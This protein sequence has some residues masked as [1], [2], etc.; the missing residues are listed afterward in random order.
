M[1]R[2]TSGFRVTYDN[3]F[4]V[5]C[6]AAIAHSKKWISNSG[7]HIACLWRP[8]TERDH[9]PPTSHPWN[10]SSGVLKKM[11]CYTRYRCHPQPFTDLKR[12]ILSR[13][14]R[15][16]HRTQDDCNHRLD[17]CSVTKGTV[18]AFVDTTWCTFC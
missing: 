13:D 4:P 7:K 15:S 8:G 6:S 14:C 3:S 5:R 1:Y 16:L 9:I 2:N 10:F 17:I 11:D 12:A 18:W